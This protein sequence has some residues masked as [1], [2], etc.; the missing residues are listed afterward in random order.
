MRTLFLLVNTYQVPLETIDEAI[1]EHRAWVVGHF[2]RGD[3]LFGGRREPRT[4]GFVVAAGDDEH[5]IREI[6][7][8]DPFVHKGYAEWEVIPVVPQFS[9]TP[10][11][12]DAFSASGVATTLPALSGELAVRVNEEAHT[13]REGSSVVDLVSSLEWPAERVSIERNGALVE[14]EHWSE[15]VLAAGDRLTVTTLTPGG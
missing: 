8:G 9:G 4:G 6:L 7:A 13:L 1:P 2:E 11:L 14:P 15:T 10:A 3:F 12:L 5:A